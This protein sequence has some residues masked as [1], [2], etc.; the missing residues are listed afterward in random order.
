MYNGFIE[1]ESNLG[2]EL[3]NIVAANCVETHAKLATNVIEDNLITK[4]NAEIA[5]AK[6][7]AEDAISKKYAT[8]F[9]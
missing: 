2:G 7:A 3:W 1:R 5:K 4:R 9:G 6:Q 8:Q